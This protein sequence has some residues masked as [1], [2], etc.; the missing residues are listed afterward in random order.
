MQLT[1]MRPKAGCH[2]LSMSLGGTDDTRTVKGKG[3]VDSGL[4]L[5]RRPRRGEVP[6]SLGTV[7]G[8]A[9]NGFCPG[10]RGELTQ[11]VGPVGH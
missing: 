3:W 5:G 7:S 8:R 2:D 6:A 4:F 11:K 9:A 1:E 10:G